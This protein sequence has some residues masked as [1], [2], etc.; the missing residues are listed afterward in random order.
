M[1]ARKSNLIDNSAPTGETWVIP[2]NAPNERI[3]IDANDHAGFVQTHTW[4]LGTGGYARARLLKSDNVDKGNIH[5]HN[6]IMRVELADWRKRFPDVKFSVD[7]LSREPLDCRR[8]NLAVK[9]IWAN[10]LNRENSGANG[11]SKYNG[12]CQD[13]TYADG[14]T[15]WLA[16]FRPNGSKKTKRIGSFRDEKAAA[17]AWDAKMLGEYGVELMTPYLN[18]AESATIFLAIQAK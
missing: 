1:P 15:K 9:P 5:L 18:F 4:S 13:G 14:S 3:L 7:H 8:S 16:N 11:S 2:T 10:N 17:A 12:V 6:H